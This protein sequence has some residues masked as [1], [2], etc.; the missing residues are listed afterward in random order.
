[1]KMY[2]VLVNQLVVMVLDKNAWELLTWAHVNFPFENQCHTGL[3]FVVVMNIRYPEARTIRKLWDI[4]F[5]SYSIG[6]YQES[7]QVHGIARKGFH[8]PSHRRLWC[9][10]IYLW[11]LPLGFQCPISIHPTSGQL[12]HWAEIPMN[13]CCEIIFL[14]KIMRSSTGVAF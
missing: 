13:I 2:F 5:I 12:L 1:M 11:R 3:S 14:T 9:G 8:E 10:K 6:A 7:Q 4:K